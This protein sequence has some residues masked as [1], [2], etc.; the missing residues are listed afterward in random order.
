MDEPRGKISV[1]YQV[2]IK[3][4]D[5]REDTDLKKEQ[6]RKIMEIMHTKIVKKWNPR[7][8]LKQNFRLK[9]SLKLCAED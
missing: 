8:R 4:K 9:I 5:I 6:L 3:M 1:K 7:S 2:M